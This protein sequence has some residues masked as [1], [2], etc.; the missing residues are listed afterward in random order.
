[1]LDCNEFLLDA[2][3]HFNH[4][5]NFVDGFC[6]GC[7]TVRSDEEPQGV[8]GDFTGDD[9]VNNDD[10]ILLLWHTLFPE[11]YPLSVNADLTGD[12]SVNNDD[13][14]LLLWHTLFPEDYPL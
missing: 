13:V 10:V 6:A 2:N 5:H 9:T 8:R 12:D 11:D 14:V 1:M 7:M 4:V 3:I